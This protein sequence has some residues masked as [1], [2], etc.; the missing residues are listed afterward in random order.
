MLAG[1]NILVA[2]QLLTGDP[3]FHLSKTAEGVYQ[4]FDLR[5]FEPRESDKDSFGRTKRSIGLMRTKETFTKDDLFHI[6]AAMSKNRALI[7]AGTGGV[8]GGEETSKHGLIQ[9]HAYSVL[10]VREVSNSSGFM[11]TS[12]DKFRMVQLRNPWGSF[13]WTGAWSDKDANWN[14][15]KNVAKKLRRNAKNGAE[16]DDDGVFWMTYDDFWE[17]FQQIDLCDRSTGFGDLAFSV[18]EQQGFC[19]P[20]RGCAWGCFKYWCMCKMCR[21]TV[22]GHVGGEPLIDGKTFFQET[23]V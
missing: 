21:A 18:D 22:F 12:R 4:R 7:G 17:N 20:A 8:D 6:L 5:Y 15:Y 19:G 9:G 13:E 3:V 16:D 1:G 11:S 14:K 10:S 23:E 2:F